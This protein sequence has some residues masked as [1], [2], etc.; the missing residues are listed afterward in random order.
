MA[1]TILV[2]GAT[3]TIGSEVVKALAAKPGVTV[4][5]AVRSAAK[6]EKLLGANVVPVDFDYEKPDTIAAAVKGADRVFLL[7]PF[8]ENQVELGKL[9]IDAAKAAGVKHIVKLSAIGA[10]IEPGIQLGRWHRATEKNIEASGIAYTFLRPANF[11]DNFIHYYPPGGDGNI[12]LPLGTGACSYI[13]SRDI[14][15]VAAAVLTEEGHYGKAYDLTGPEAVTTAE[16]ASA[17]G[18]VSGRDVHYVDVPDAAAS[19]AMTDMQMPGWMVEAM[20]ELHGIVKA[21]YAS[22][23]SPLVEQLTG[24]AP[25]SFAEFARDRAAAWKPKG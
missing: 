5:V 24:K 17:I 15:A 19:K 1:S 25:R 3:G 6:A 4:R 21:G 12:Y 7:T 9:L 8:A 14:A 18:A 23:I 2:T 11:M 13:D 16:A 22:A 10:N 20:M